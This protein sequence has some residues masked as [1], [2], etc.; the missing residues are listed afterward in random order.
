MCSIWNPRPPSAGEDCSGGIC[1]WEALRIFRPSWIPP[2]RRIF[3]LRLPH[4][5]SWLASRHL[6]PTQKMKRIVFDNWF[7]MAVAAV[8]AIRIRAL[9]SIPI[10]ISGKDFFVR[11]ALSTHSPARRSWSIDVCICALTDAFHI[12]SLC[13]A[14][15]PLH[16]HSL[17]PPLFHDYT[18]RNEN[19][20][21]TSAMRMRMPWNSLHEVIEGAKKRHNINEAHTV[22]HIT[23]TRKHT[24]L[25]TRSRSCWIGI[26]IAGLQVAYQSATALGMVVF[27]S[28]LAI[29]FL[30]L[31]FL[32]T[33]FV[34]SLL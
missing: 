20:W 8:G 25:N 30:H 31:R 3:G 5:K 22:D 21:V 32:F 26:C 17:L 4:R 12:T 13:R 16:I 10:L 2:T 28:L 9:D 29:S 6:A 1:V 18:K 24:H 7:L 11:A 15:S 23:R 14:E 33:A 19:E 34:I 27:L